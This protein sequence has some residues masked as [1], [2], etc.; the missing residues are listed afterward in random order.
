M[1]RILWSDAQ[2]AGISLA[3][4]CDAVLLVVAY[5]RNTERH[6]ASAISILGRDKIMGF[7]FNDRPYVPEFEW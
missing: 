2:E 1:D 3:D 5:G 6:I 7:V 4:I